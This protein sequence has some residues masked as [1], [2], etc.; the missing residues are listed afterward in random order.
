MA[1]EID[2]ATNAPDYASLAKQAAGEPYDVYSPVQYPWMC[3][4]YFVAFWLAACV[5]KMIFEKGFFKS[6]FENLPEDKKRN[7]V[8]YV[9]QLVTTRF[10]LAA[11]I[12][13]G[14]DVMFRG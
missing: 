3:F 2:T 12:C 4:N 9:L 10:G 14:R 8:I 6:R 1:M 11:Q 13:R 7:T 5:L